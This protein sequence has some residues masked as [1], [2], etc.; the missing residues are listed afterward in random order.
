M[1][2]LH[3]AAGS[4]LLAISLAVSANAAI[5]PAAEP[6]DRLENSPRHHEW[7]TLKTD[8]DRDVRAFVVFP[9]VDRPVPAVVVIHE[10]RGLNEWARSLADQVAEAGFVAVAPD[11]LSGMGPDGGGTDSFRNSDAAREAIYKLTPERVNAGLDAAVK[12]AKGLEATSDVVTVAGFCW[13]G[14]QSFRYATHNPAIAAAFVFYGSAPEN[15]VL[16]QLKVPVY[17]FYGGNDFRITGQVPRV[18]MRTDELSKPFEPVVYDSAG[19]GFMRSGEAGNANDANRRGRSAAWERWI[20][21]MND[22]GKAE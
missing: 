10:N 8:G 17:G 7:V 16:G 14:G 5:P 20:K 11:L 1:N 22:L 21:L 9:E 4:A 15:E 2:P 18:K 19:H 12:H 13:G 3:V 6:G